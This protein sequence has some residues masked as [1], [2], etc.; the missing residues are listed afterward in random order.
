MLIAAAMVFLVL[1]P[2][3]AQG[4][5]PVWVGQET[6]GD[7]AAVANESLVNHQGAMTWVNSSI[8]WMTTNDY[9]HM[10]FYDN[11]TGHRIANW[12]E[13]CQIHGMNGGPLYGANGIFVNASTYSYQARAAN[14]S[15]TLTITAMQYRIAMTALLDNGPYR[16]WEAVL[17]SRTLDINGSASYFDVFISPLGLGQSMAIKESCVVA[18]GNLTLDQAL[19]APSSALAGEYQL[20]IPERDY[21]LDVNGGSEMGRCTFHLNVSRV[22]STVGALHYIT[23]AVAQVGL[24]NFM[25]TEH[26]V[27]LVNITPAI[28]SISYAVDLPPAPAQNMDWLPYV[29]IVVIV[30]V[31][32]AVLLIAKRRK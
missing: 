10:Y 3:M 29:I 14:N 9:S 27:G 4:T 19:V 8:G 32:A 16:N 2:G 6:G 15:G 13:L 17:R 24:M 26:E 12:T 25:P 28:V 22:T 11:N 30:M 1:T 21:W 23:K 7:V 18:Q 20:T 31:A 5:A